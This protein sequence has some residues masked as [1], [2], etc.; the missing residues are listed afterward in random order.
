MHAI[1]TNF[2]PTGVHNDGQRHGREHTPCM[3]LARSVTEAEDLPHAIKI[4]RRSLLRNSQHKARFSSA[5]CRAPC[6]INGRA[7]SPGFSLIPRSVQKADSPTK[8]ARLAQARHAAGPFSAPES[9]RPFRPLFSRLIGQLQGTVHAPLI[10][11]VHPIPS[12]F[13][14][15]RYHKTGA[16]QALYSLY[17]YLYR[18][19]HN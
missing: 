14:P 13:C 15:H 6:T 19:I 2:H 9:P 11:V 18:I 10:T 7:F 17:I 16:A 4:R 8:A 1:N 3:H 5:F 12:S